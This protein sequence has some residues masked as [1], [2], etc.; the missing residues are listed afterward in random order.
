MRTRIPPKTRVFQVATPCSPRCSVDSM[1]DQSVVPKGMADICMSWA[2]RGLCATPV[3][4]H[5]TRGR[6]L[7]YA[8]RALRQLVPRLRR[9]T[10]DVKRRLDPRRIVERR[11]LQESHARECRRL[12]EQGRPAASTES[13]LDRLARRAFS[14]ERLRRAVDLKRRSGDNHVD[15]VATAAGLLARTTMAERGKGGLRRRPVANCTA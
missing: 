12:G 8:G 15:R 13:A 4:R 11:G 14:A 10:P 2:P 5:L 6:V 1:P 7:G 3:R 9:V